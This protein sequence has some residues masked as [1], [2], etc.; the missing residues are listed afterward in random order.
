MAWDNKWH[1]Y[2]IDGGFH[3]W[4]TGAI[5][6]PA[7]GHVPFIIPRWG[8]RHL[9]S[10]VGARAIHYPALGHAISAQCGLSTR[11]LWQL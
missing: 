1:P 2:T 9:L 4:C 11:Y 10:R 5:Y 6:Y 3:P 7:L 8:T